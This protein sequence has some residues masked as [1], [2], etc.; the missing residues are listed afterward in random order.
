MAL[1]LQGHHRAMMKR[2]A[3]AIKEAKERIFVRYR[4]LNY[5]CNIFF[6]K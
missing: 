5:L 6:N 2:C 4:Y 3:A 1:F